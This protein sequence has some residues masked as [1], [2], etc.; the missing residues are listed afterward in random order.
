MVKVARE[1]TF[2]TV[3]VDFNV[4]VCTDFSAVR[5]TDCA[6]SFLVFLEIVGAVFAVITWTASFVTSLL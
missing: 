3:D 2:S 4:R 1:A 6:R 5:C